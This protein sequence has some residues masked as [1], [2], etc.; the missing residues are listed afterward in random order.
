M[1]TLSIEEIKERLS[2]ICSFGRCDVLARTNY[3]DGPFKWYVRLQGV[4]VAFLSGGGCS[5]V[6]LEGNSGANPEQAVRTVWNHVLILACESEMA[7][8]CSICSDRAPDGNAAQILVRWDD[9]ADDWIDVPI[10]QALVSSRKVRPYK[11][12]LFFR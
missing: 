6:T 8:R 9:S 11:Q 2:R 7:L 1:R 4:D 5:S 10:P 12:Q 3:P